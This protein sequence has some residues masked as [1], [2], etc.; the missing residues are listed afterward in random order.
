MATIRVLIISENEKP[1]TY[2]VTANGT[3]L[4]GGQLSGPV[5]CVTTDEAAGILTVTCDESQSTSRRRVQVWSGDTLVVDHIADPQ[6]G[7][8][9]CAFN[10]DLGPLQGCASDDGSQEIGDA[11]TNE[12]ANLLVEVLEYANDNGVSQQ[13]LERLRKFTG[14]G[15][16]FE[17]QNAQSLLRALK[18]DERHNSWASEKLKML[19]KLAPARALIVEDPSCPIDE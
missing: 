1:F 14:S 5:E 12:L 7:G 11:M 8:Y 16:V 6:G 13:S 17:T 19:K 9:S 10:F 15:T 3:E 18:D 4:G 2:T